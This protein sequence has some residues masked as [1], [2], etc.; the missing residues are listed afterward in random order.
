MEDGCVELKRARRRRLT[1]NAIERQKRIVK[2]T[3]GRS[4]TDQPHRYAKMHA[5]SCGIP[6]CP[7]CSNPRRVWRQR[8]LQERREFQ[9][10]E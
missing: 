2:D 6:G 9:K 3:R 4:P 1:T 7:A 5:L 10:G 8:T